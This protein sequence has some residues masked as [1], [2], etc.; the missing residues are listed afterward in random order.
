VQ[1]GTNGKT[2]G[3]LKIKY[4][5]MKQAGRDGPKNHHTTLGGKK[6]TAQRGRR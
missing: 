3:G 4:I 6:A 5:R 2:V 1:G